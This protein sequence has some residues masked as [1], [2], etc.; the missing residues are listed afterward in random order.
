MI[1]KHTHPP[2]HWLITTGSR[3]SARTF[4][5][6]LLLSPLSPS[7]PCAD[8]YIEETQVFGFLF[9][10]FSPSC[11]ILLLTYTYFN[12]YGKSSGPL[13]KRKKRRD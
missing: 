7:N 5:I 8:G 3:R 6:T 10:S 1:E 4:N 12:Y 11:Y 2:Y 9:S 13:E